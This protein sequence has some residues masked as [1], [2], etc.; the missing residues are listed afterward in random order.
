MAQ[1]NLPPYISYLIFGYILFALIFILMSETAM[2][3]PPKPTRFTAD[4][5]TIE[6]P[7][8]NLQSI[9]AV[10]LPHPE[11]KYTILFSHGNAEDLGYAMPYLK[12]YQSL[13][14]S[15]FAYDYPG[16]G[17]SEGKPTEQSTYQAIEKSYDY[18]TK[19]KN[20]DP[21]TIVIHGRSLG[22]GPS[23]EWASKVPAT[24]VSLESPFLSAV[25]VYTQIPLFPFDKYQNLKKISAI[26]VP[27]LVIHG[28]KD[29]VIP[30]WHGKTIYQKLSVPKQYYWVEGANHND[31]IAVNPE[32]YWLTLQNFLNDFLTHYRSSAKTSHSS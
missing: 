31:T 21:K 17:T 11:A 24:G 16:Y 6:L 32:A 4:E 10:Y 12:Y 29:K 5:H 22:T 19:I 7:L 28:T 15:I 27:T 3:V 30:F 26:N 8:D 1:F 20:I 23:I 14:F 2:F 13:G 9:T 25:R 18:L